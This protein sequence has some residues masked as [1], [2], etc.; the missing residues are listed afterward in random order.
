MSQPIRV[1]IAK[2]GLDGHWRGVT[3][4]AQAMRDAGFEV[5]MLGMATAEQIA[6]AARDEDVEL[7]GL[8]IGGRVEVAERAI[9]A[10]RAVD[11]DLPILVGGTIPP[12]AATRLRAARTAARLLSPLA[13]VWA[14][15]PAPSTEPPPRSRDW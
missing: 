14:H 10:V 11:P 6:A 4:V 9:S 1:L 3:V 15:R 12:P 2:T 7:V 8:N 5:V 13:G